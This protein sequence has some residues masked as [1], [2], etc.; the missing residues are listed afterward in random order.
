[1]QLVIITDEQEKLIN[2]YTPEVVTD[3]AAVVDMDKVPAEHKPFVKTVI[4]ANIQQ[5]VVNRVLPTQKITIQKSD[6][7]SKRVSHNLTV[8]ATGLA[9][10]I[11]VKN[12]P[13]NGLWRMYQH[14]LESFKH[15]A[16]TNRTEIK[17]LFEKHGDT[18]TQATDHLRYL[19][20]KGVLVEGHVDIST[21]PV[22]DVYLKYV[23]ANV[24]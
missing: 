2:K 20:Q 8:N 22:G 11:R 10:E 6:S 12:G 14:L 13:N 17:A 1:M 23:S 9:D 15:G 7:D 4:A 3:L 16:R 18:Q 19:V 24:A 21:L 5:P